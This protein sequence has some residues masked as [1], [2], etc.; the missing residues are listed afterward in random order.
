M[1]GWGEKP[2]TPT[3]HYSILS[4]LALKFARFPF[5][6]IGESCNHEKDSRP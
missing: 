5:T 6:F 4:Y 3:L 1:E 2:N